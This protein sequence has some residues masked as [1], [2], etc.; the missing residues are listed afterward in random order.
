[1]DANEILRV[2][3]DLE[4]VDTTG[5]VFCVI[6]D[7]SS[8]AIGSGHA[9]GKVIDMGEPHF[10]PFQKGEIL[11]LDGEYGREPFGEG[12]KPAK[13]DVA[14]EYFTTLAEAEA[15]REQVLAGKWPRR[16]Q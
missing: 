7:A 1:M 11:V 4:P 14:E 6:S 15:C 16:Y 8:L 2:L 9:A 5:W 3:N 10:W 12:R 13:W